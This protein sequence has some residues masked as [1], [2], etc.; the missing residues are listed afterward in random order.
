MGYYVADANGY[1]GD[2]A[3]GGGLRAFSEWAPMSGPVREFLR[4]GYSYGTDQLAQTL[5]EM[6]SDNPAVDSVRTELAG[7]ARQAEVL[8][9]LS[10]GGT[11]D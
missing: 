10:D 11:D 4:D 2:I 5:N 9:I 7:Y 3:S 8:L 6:K 1:L